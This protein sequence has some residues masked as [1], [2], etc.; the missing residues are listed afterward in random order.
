MVKGQ[1]K[2]DLTCYPDAVV[3]L[4]GL[5]SLQL[6]KRIWWTRWTSPVDTRPQ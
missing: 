1:L 4:D 5:G 2:R 3:Q 6:E